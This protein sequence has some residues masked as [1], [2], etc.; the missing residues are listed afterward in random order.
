MINPGA[1]DQAQRQDS[2]NDSETVNGAARDNAGSSSAELSMAVSLRLQEDGSTLAE[3]KIF[4]CAAPPL[5][6]RLH[7]ERALLAT[8]LSKLPEYLPRGQLFFFSTTPPT[9]DVS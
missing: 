7:P 1:A 5:Y 4:V 3:V 8:L 6:F 9:A 2:K